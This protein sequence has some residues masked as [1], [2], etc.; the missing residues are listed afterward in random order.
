[1]YYKNGAVLL[2]CNPLT[3]IMFVPEVDW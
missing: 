2:F 3:G 1:M